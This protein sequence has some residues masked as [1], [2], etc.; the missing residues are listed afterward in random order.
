MKTHPQPVCRVFV[1]AV[2]VSVALSQSAVA[3]N[4]SAETFP[5]GRAPIDY[6]GEATDDPISRL[7]QKLEAGQV[8]LRHDKQYG[9]L[10][11]VLQI[12]EIPVESQILV[13]SK[14]SVNRRLISPINPRAIYFN[15]KI[16]IG[17]TPGAKALELSTVDPQ[18]G[19]MFYVLEQEEV[20]KPRFARANNCLTCH[21]GSNSLHVPGHLVRSFFTDQQ[22]EPLS[23]RS[24]VTHNTPLAKRWGG[25]YVTGD[26][27]E[28]SHMGNVFG[29]ESI[30]EHRED[31]LFHGNVT[32]LAAYLDMSSYLTPHS[33]IVALMILD[34][35]ANMQNLLTRLTYETRLQRTPTVE[36]RLLRYMFFIDEPELT[37]DVL[38]ESGY[39]EA[40]EFVGPE[41]SH[42]RSL[43]QL[44][45]STRMF[46]YRLS[47]QIYT[48]AFQKLPPSAK[49]RMYQR[50]WGVLTETEKDPAYQ[51]IPQG[52]RQ[53]ILEI[54]RETLD[55][56][57]AYFLK[58]V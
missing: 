28:Q 5:Y 48:P 31:P 3:Q 55:D 6:Q 34:H 11:S 38:G 56:L 51:K 20:A 27:G 50:I 25:W 7:N 21:A 30:R 37:D 9:Y 16:Y 40:F 4:S 22:G 14:T 43:R 32:D 10:K 19:G 18:K 39:A 57:P 58:G 42:G 41:D 2:T 53:A 35:Q 1:F 47:Y 8:N 24:R 17:W 12:F 54:L 29:N 49:E 45:L 46:K 13:F 23:G 36:N 52:E 33:D 26:H 44:D 15:D